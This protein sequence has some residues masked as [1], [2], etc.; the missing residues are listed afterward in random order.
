MKILIAP[1]LYLLLFAYPSYGLTETSDY[2]S[3]RERFHHKKKY[4]LSEG[5]AKIYIK[6]KSIV[7]IGEPHFN[8]SSEVYPLILT[9]IQINGF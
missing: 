1:F 4:S 9:E 5:I 3:L 2:C 7:F 6:E 8:F